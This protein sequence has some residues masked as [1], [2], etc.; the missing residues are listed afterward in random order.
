MA[1]KFQPSRAYHKSR[2]NPEGTV[3]EIYRI[4]HEGKEYY[5][6]GVVDVGFETYTLYI[7]DGWVSDTKVYQWKVYSD[8]AAS[9]SGDAVKATAVLTTAMQNLAEPEKGRAQGFLTIIN[10]I[11]GSPSP[12]Y[13]EVG[14]QLP[15]TLPGSQ[16]SST[17]K[18]PKKKLTEQ[19]WFYPTIAGGI[20]LISAVTIYAFTRKRKM[21]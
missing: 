9:G 6:R 20:V 10:A 18:P 2:V 4:Q 15:T 8:G 7:N 3:G 11:A 16:Q 5:V 19:V 13:Q 21:L 14:P 1:V 12:E 17:G